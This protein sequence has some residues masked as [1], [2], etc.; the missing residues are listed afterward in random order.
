MGSLS[1]KK[2]SVDR[3]NLSGTQQNTRHNAQFA[4]HV[5]YLL[6]I[7]VIINICTCRI[8]RMAVISIMKEKNNR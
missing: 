5:S 6:K 4:A 3:D 2:P 1:F 7:C 8:I